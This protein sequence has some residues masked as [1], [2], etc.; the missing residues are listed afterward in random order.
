MGLA[1]VMERSSLGLRARL[2]LLVLVAVIP[3]FAS[4]AYN[5]MQEREQAEIGAER[6]ALNLSRLAAREQLQLVMATRQLLV[7]LSQMPAL[8][9]PATAADCNRVLREVQKPYPHYT[10]IGV[11]TTDGTIYCNSL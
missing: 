2:L 7:G 4:I 1:S 10:N 11:A 9:G 8:R 6:D 5:A 3:A